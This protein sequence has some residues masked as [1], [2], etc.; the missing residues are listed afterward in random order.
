MVV[1]QSLTLAFN[2]GILNT[3]IS[4]NLVMSKQSSKAPRFKIATCKTIFL[5]CSIVMYSYSNAQDRGIHFDHNASWK[6]ILAKARAENKYI[7]VD[8]FTTWC[9]PCKYMSNVVFPMEEV[10]DFFNDKFINVAM[11]FDSTIN[12]AEHIKARYAD[13]AFISGKYKINGYPTFLFFSPDGE[14]LDRKTGSCAAK[15]FITIGTNALD[16]EKQYYTQIKKYNAGERDL[17]FLND[18]ALMALAAFDDSLTEEFAKENNAV[19]NDANKSKLNN[20]LKQ[21]IFSRELKSADGWAKLEKW[22]N[23]QWHIYSDKIR[24]TYPLFAE[25]ILF[26]F[27]IRV[28]QNKNNWDEF[29]KTVT[30]YANNKF[31]SSE[32]L[33]KCAW[34]IFANCNDKKILNEALQWSRRSFTNQERIAPDFIDIYANLLYK[35][36][37]KNEAIEWEQKAQKIVI[38]QGGDKNWGQDVIDKMNR[39]EE[40]W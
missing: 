24:K 8:C 9:G 31:A 14:L 17:I 29:N 20:R 2:A 39:G 15:E 18:L 12:D 35:L 36:G 30:K 32:D 22:D 6:G 38:E 13:A 19:F 1:M 16:P 37:R 11:Q 25:D 7:F 21:I 3:E 4:L 23:E 26:D 28:Y 27:K 40:T 33:N 5:I 10:G 34:L